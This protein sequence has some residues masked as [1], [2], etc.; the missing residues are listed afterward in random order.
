MSGGGGGGTTISTAELPPELRPLFSGAGTQLLAT[1][2]ALPLSQFAAWNPGSVAGIAPLQQE[3]LNLLPSTAQAPGGLQALY[4]SAPGLNAAATGLYDVAGQTGPM[5]AALN[6]LSNSGRIAPMQLAGS[7]MSTEQFSNTLP[8]APSGALFP[9][10]PPVPQGAA[11]GPVAMTTPGRPDQ[12][13]IPTMD[14]IRNMQA[15]ARTVQP[16]FNDVFEMLR[17]Y[18]NQWNSQA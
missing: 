6:T 9:G 8:N 1:Q 10:M 4:G 12:A 5:Q 14:N 18:N 2:R 3:A 7:P 17:Y 15:E 16:R 11:T 13:Q